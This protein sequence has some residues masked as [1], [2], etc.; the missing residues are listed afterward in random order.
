M[1]RLLLIALIVAAAADYFVYDSRYSRATADYVQRI[2]R[3]VNHGV[4][5]F[6][7]GRR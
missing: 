6:F 1:F 5:D 7:K 3:D 2:S 4:A